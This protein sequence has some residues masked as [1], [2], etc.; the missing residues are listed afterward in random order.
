[1]TEN[2]GDAYSPP[3]QQKSGNG[4]GMAALVLGIVATVF[5]I[6]P[7]IGIVSLI[8][9]P[10]AIIFGILGIRKKF[11]PRGKSIAGIILGA[12]ALITAI[13]MSVVVG[14]AI[15]AIDEELNNPQATVES[16][17]E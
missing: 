16:S 11:R 12:I 2:P 6:I 17:P 4:F 7:V 15:N 3:E 14:S 10:L 13:I 5:S 8:L 1:M 9:A